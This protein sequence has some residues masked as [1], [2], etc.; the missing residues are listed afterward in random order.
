MKEFASLMKKKIKMLIPSLN[1]FSSLII[2]HIF[3]ALFC[4]ANTCKNESLH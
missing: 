1:V 2:Q 3:L 4:A